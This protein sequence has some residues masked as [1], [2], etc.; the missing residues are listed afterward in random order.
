M[1]LKSRTKILS[2]LLIFCFAST[3]ALAV[4]QTASTPESTAKQIYMV[5]FE[6]GAVL[7]EK[8]SNEKMPTSSMSKVMT[9][10]MVF[11]ALKNKKMALDDTLV[12]SEKAWRIQGSKMF[13][14]IGESIKVEDLIRGVI[15][16]SGNDATIVLAE[17]LAG[18][19][20]AFADAMN[21][22][23]KELGMNDSHFM[24]ASGWPDPDHY[25]TAHDLALMAKAVITEHPEHYGY[26]SE[27]EY[28]YNNIKQGNRN[29]LLYKDIGAD[30]LK[31]GHTEDGGYGLI[32][33]GVKDGRRVIMVLNGMTSMK[34]R[35]EE[36][37]RLLQ[38]GLNGFKNVSLLKDG[39]IL[40]KAPVVL[41][42]KTEV[43][44]TFGKNIRITEPKLG[45]HEAPKIEVTYKSPLIAPIAKGAE[46]GTV[47]I[48]MKDGSIQESPLITM[49]S[50]EEMSYAL[51]LIQKARL[52][53]TGKGT[54]GG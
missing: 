3:P 44:L 51:K 18:S 27:K 38:W 52:L 25:S 43:P 39:A 5:D 1:S 2:T 45:Q 9:M 21:K 26:Y 23:A 47:K 12:V 35:A 31:T 42:N 28:T 16:Q 54:I 37:V 32:G 11:D 53:T 49:E 34:I 8:N 4:A 48:E 19:E 14:P 15:I 33:T 40:D 46:V 29:P 13:V 7:L 6:T 17:A 20:E 10:Y 36:S 41:G 22:K 30:G 24:N 50:V